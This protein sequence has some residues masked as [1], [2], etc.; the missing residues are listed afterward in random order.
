[1]A[2]YRVFL[3]RSSLYLISDRR[4][5]FPYLKK[6]WPLLVT[7]NAYIRLLELHQK[8]LL[9]YPLNV[10]ISPLHRE[11]PASSILELIT[12]MKNALFS[13]LRRD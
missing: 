9:S 2:V 1:L 12:K 7:N 13:I 6:L 8:Q 5:T 11:A 4:K 3:A 10:A